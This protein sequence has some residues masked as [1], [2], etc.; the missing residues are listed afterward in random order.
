M[1]RSRATPIVPPSALRK[2]PP[3]GK[4]KLDAIL[5]SYLSSKNGARRRDA[6]EWRKRMAATTSDGNKIEIRRLVSDSA[7][8]LLGTAA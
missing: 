6:T 7:K 2:V 3:F 4:L 1:G 8:R 5:G